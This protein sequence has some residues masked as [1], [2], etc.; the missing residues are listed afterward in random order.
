MK[1]GGLVFLEDP[2]CFNNEN[3]IFYAPTLI[4]F[5]QIKKELL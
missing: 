1:I 2:V 5:K 4:L 3:Q